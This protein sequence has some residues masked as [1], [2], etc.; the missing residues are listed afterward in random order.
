MNIYSIPEIRSATAIDTTAIVDLLNQS[1][2]GESAKQGWTS[3]THLI[4]GNVRTTEAEVNHLIAK[5]GSIILVY[6]NESKEITKEII[7]CV[8]LQHQSNRLY[9]GMLAVKPL[10]QGQGVGKKLLRAADEHAKA[11]RVNQI[12]MTVVSV[13]HELIEWY[14]R[15]G[16][17]LTGEKFPF[18]EDGVTG[19]HLQK[20]E[21]AV[22]EKFLIS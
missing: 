10:L 20:L 12:V 13:R 4:S 7:G 21:F 14:E 2:R 22:L 15:H 18:P 1:Y 5:P 17:H 9:L 16:F 11:L 6:K 8:N 3:E 19:T